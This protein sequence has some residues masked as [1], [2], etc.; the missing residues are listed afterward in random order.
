M[1]LLGTLLAATVAG[2]PATGYRF[3][4]VALGMVILRGVAR[5]W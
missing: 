1:Y 2:L 4:K 5:G 3:S